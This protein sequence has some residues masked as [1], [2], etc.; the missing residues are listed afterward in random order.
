MVAAIDWP[1]ETRPF[2]HAIKKTADAGADAIRLRLFK[3]TDISDVE[4]LHE[5]ALEPD[6]R[7]FRRA[8]DLA[9]DRG[10]LVL[11]QPHAPWAVREMR[12]RVDAYKIASYDYGR[13]DVIG[14][15]DDRKVFISAGQIP[16]QDIKVIKERFN[17]AHFWH[18]VNER[19]CPPRHAA[20][21][22]IEK[23]KLRGYADHTLN[24]TVCAAAAIIGVYFIEVPV[25]TGHSFN[26]GCE[27]EQFEE[28]VRAVR[29]ARGCLNRCFGG[30]R[31]YSKYFTP[32]EPP[33][34]RIVTGA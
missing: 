24:P 32:S 17:R 15:C 4:P 6:V 9:H 7:T 33:Y 26:F 18:T 5:A 21:W 10:M 30:R 22:R 28:I 1:G 14:L 29:T 25:T 8:V 19:P 2:M 20:L 12:G 23:D 34:G 16:G 11:G 27:P 13:G 3:W 31:S